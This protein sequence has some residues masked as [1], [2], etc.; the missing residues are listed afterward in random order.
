MVCICACG[1]CMCLWCVYVLVVGGMGQSTLSFFTSVLATPQKAPLFQT[2]RLL[3][4]E[5]RGEGKRL[6]KDV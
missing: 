5:G 1:V 3:G 6:S 2:V 4:P